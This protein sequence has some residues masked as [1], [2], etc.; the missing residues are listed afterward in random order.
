MAMPAYPGLWSEQ[1][2]R[3]GNLGSTL[4]PHWFASLS[5]LFPNP[6]PPSLLF[7]NLLPSETGADPLRTDL[8][9]AV[10]VCFWIQTFATEANLQD[11]VWP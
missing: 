4:C 9:S 3:E 10:K 7:F 6:P 5:Y 1:L 2:L 8:I 11:R